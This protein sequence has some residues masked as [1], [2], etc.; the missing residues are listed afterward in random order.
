MPSGAEDGLDSSSTMTKSVVVD[1]VVQPRTARTEQ[2][3]SGTLNYIYNGLWEDHPSVVQMYVGFESGLFRSYPGAPR[4]SASYDPRLR[5]WYEAADQ[6]GSGIVHA[7]PYP[8]ANGAGWMISP[9]VLIRDGSSRFGVAAADIK[10]D[11]IQHEILATPGASLLRI[12]GVVVASTYW[13]TTVTPGPEDEAPVI[14]DLASHYSR[15][16]LSELT[17]TSAGLAARV[18]DV[19]AEDGTA[20][21]IARAF[22]PPT[23]EDTDLSQPRYVLLVELNADNELAVADGVSERFSDSSVGLSIIAVVLSVLSVVVVTAVVSALANSVTAPL[24]QVRKLSR[25]VTNNA[26]GD[27]GRGLRVSEL[28]ASASGPACWRGDDEVKQFVGE[29]KKLMQGLSSKSAGKSI[30]TNQG[31]MAPN[32][33]RAH[34]AP[35]SSSLDTIGG[36]VVDADGGGDSRRGG[37]GG[38][39]GAES[40]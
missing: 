39:G 12:D 29:V 19:D 6:Q 24:K 5:P 33:F 27:L 14:W 11:D 3:M 26:A 36:V 9:S 7:A 28:D 4:A 22:V 20:L 35:W 1:G 18:F 32:P 23:L 2:L 13:D 8:D 17:D 37:A 25:A 16:F 31:K 15:S 30:S 40:K 21:F 34:T 10:I 38:A